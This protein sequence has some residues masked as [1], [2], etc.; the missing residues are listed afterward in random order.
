M[1]KHC[2]ILN[3]PN[4]NKGKDKIHVFSFP[5]IESIAAKWIE[6]TGRKK[7]IPNKYSA[8]CDIH[9]KLED[10]SNTT[11]RVRLKPDV[12][13]TKNLINCTSTER[14]KTIISEVRKQISSN[15]KEIEIKFILKLEEGEQNS[16]C[17]LEI[18]NEIQNSI[19]ET[20]TSETL[21]RNDVLT[22]QEMKMK[23]QKLEKKNEE[24][25]NKLQ[26]LQINLE[27]KI[28][29][30]ANVSE[31]KLQ[32][33]TARLKCIVEEQRKKFKRKLVTKEKQLKILRIAVRRKNNHIKNLLDIVKIKKILTKTS[34]NTLKHDFGESSFLVKN[35]TQNQNKSS[36]RSIL[37]VDSY[38]LDHLKC[39]PKIS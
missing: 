1:T 14:V 24:L 25:I 27:E 10:F 36:H 20:N 7:F 33:Q 39:N 11:R 38:I 13:P 29:V 37:I 26:S 16:I 32:C 5:Q 22:F 30:Q 28:Q 4:R 31:K 17:K 35:E 23:I 21:K 8:I 2:E 6:A 12:V 34:Y 9:F 15:E 19:Y 18:E 3:C